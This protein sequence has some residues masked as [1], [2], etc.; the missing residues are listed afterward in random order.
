MAYDLV[1]IWENIQTQE[2]VECPII[3]GINRYIG[4]FTNDLRRRNAEMKFIQRD[5]ISPIVRYKLTNINFFDEHNVQIPRIGEFTLNEY[6]YDQHTHDFS[7]DHTFQFV[8]VERSEVKRYTNEC[9]HERMSYLWPELQ[10]GSK[11]ECPKSSS[12][13]SKIV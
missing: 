8:V 1:L 3:P 6:Y 2:Q 5:D 10:K 9:F 11:C 12:S 4:D 7:R 13:F